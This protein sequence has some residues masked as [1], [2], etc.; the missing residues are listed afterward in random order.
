MDRKDMHEDKD[1]LEEGGV[2]SEK[3]KGLSAFN[4]FL[5]ATKKLY[6]VSIATHVKLFRSTKSLTLQF[7]FTCCLF[8]LNITWMIKTS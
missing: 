8:L 7:K 2:Q 1:E 4:L 3:V 5:I 6:V